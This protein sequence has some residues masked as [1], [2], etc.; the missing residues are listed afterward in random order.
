MK[1]WLDGQLLPLD[2]A[3]VSPLA[4]G[5]HY[6]TGV[7][8]GI[9]AYATPEGPAIFRL[10]DHLERMARGCSAIALPFDVAA[11]E[12]ACLDVLEANELGDA[13]LRPLAFFETGSLGL[14]V[15][16]LKA[17]LL[18]AALPWKSH[19]G[20]A[21]SKGVA[22]LSSAWRRN[23]RHA[24]PPLKL[25]GG[26]VNSILAKREATGLGYDEALFMD[27]QGRV[28]EATGENLFI[29]KGGKVTANEH[30]DALP[31]IT[32]DTVIA[33]TG[34]ARKGLTRKEVVDAD[35]VFLTGTSAEVAAVAR[36]DQHTFGANPFTREL[37]ARYAQL[38]RGGDPTR[39]GW[40]TRL[41]PVLAG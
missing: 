30:P 18:V 20:E 19:L 28:V 32:R 9:R 38:V 21:G 36:L 26:Y 31:G 23:S 11:A 34:A 17:R 24:L 37:Q 12:R 33:L 27:R 22:M 39:E 6:G 8:E 15:H 35:E 7:F 40:L 10:K 4:H 16:N 2:Q 5:L 14:D 1:V 41:R 3:G 13:Y 25:C 29:V